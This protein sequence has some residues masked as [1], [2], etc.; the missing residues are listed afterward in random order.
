M[1]CFREETL[2]SADI[3][4]VSG[5]QVFAAL[6]RLYGEVKS[7]DPIDDGWLAALLRY[8]PDCVFIILHGGAGENGEIQ[9]LLE[10][11][12]LTYTGSD[13]V[14]SSRCMNKIQAKAHL[15]AY[16]DF[17]FPLLYGKKS[18]SLN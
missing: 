15:S 11:N 9:K 10:R 16:E 3:S 8:Q 2:R 7:F 14:S 13:S 6:N 5:E 12:G 17:L 18:Q 1:R 4:L